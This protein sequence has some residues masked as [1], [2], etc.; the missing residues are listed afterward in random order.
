MAMSKRFFIKLAAEYRGIRPAANGSP[1]YATWAQMVHI[2]A[3]ALRTQ[4][5]SF[6]FQRFYEA[7]GVQP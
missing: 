6:N 2:T 4:N 1:E 5:S 7:C 3:E